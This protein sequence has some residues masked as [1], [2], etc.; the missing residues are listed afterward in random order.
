MAL[1]W[2]YWWL[3]RYENFSLFLHGFS[4]FMSRSCPGCWQGTVRDA[5]WNE[6]CARQ[7]RVQRIEQALAVFA[8]SREAAADLAENV[9]TN[10][11]NSNFLV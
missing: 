9:G 4:S 7:S 8:C 3:K 2:A 11:K 5:N 1:P 10:A 6:R